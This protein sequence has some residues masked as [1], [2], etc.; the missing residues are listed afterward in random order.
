MYFDRLFKMNWNFGLLMICE[1]L[2]Y[3]YAFKSMGSIPPFHMKWCNAV[4]L[5]ELFNVKRN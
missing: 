3:E 1:L 2:F 5:S 4:I